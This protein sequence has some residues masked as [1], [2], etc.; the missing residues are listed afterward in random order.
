ML[1]DG[2]FRLMNMSLNQMLLMD[3]RCV[4]KLEKS[5]FLKGQ[6][7]MGKLIAIVIALLVFAVGLSLL[8]AWP[9]LLLWNYVMP[10]AFP[11]AGIAELDFW[12]AF[13][14]NFLCSILFKSASASASS[15]S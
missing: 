1:A 8:A 14:L 12:H 13:A 9:T 10:F 11:R 5:G 4:P 15:S 6:K 3:V 7:K 2:T